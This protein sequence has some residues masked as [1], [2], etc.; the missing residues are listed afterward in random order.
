MPGLKRSP[1]QI[2]PHMSPMDINYDRSPEASGPPPEGMDF[3]EP[4][5]GES[6]AET[7]VSKTDVSVEPPSEKKEGGK[8]ASRKKKKS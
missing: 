6:T 5:E 1:M 7:A 3:D 8:A 2:G 4:S